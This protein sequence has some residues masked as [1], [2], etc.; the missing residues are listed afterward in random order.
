MVT[1]SEV[2]ADGAAASARAAEP[3]AKVF[4]SYSRKDMAFAD[5]LEAALEARGIEPL[6]DRSEIYAFE[7]WWRRIEALIAQ[8]DTVVFVL[9]PDAA[10]SEVCHKEIAFAASCNKRLAPIVYRRVDDK[11]LPQALASLNFIFL[12]DE[13]RFEA[14]VDRLVEA[15]NTDIDWIRK[16]TEVGEQSRR[17]ALAKRPRGLL[18]RSPMLEEAERWIASR[19][20]GAPVPT[21][22]MQGFIRRSRRAATRRRNI[23]TAGL[24]VGLLAAL[25]LAGLAYWQ[26]GAAIEQRDK[27]L[28][29]QSRFLADF[30]HQNIGQDDGTAMLLAVEALPDARAGVVRPYAAEAEVA[31]YSARQGLMETTV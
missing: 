8:A 4:I 18:L 10:S 20:R 13:A 3:K 26:R 12:D 30:A 16:H 21:E 28:L 25:G 9:S 2:A 23:V 22:D 5:R 17:W 15:L 24:A 1:Q 11:A 29:T 31:L 19:P 27:G 7:D 6:I 14:S